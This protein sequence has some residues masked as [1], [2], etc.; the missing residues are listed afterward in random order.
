M[1]KELSRVLRSDE[2]NVSLLDNGI[3][4]A[5]NVPPSLYFIFLIGQ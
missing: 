3:D 1:Y 4:L 2:V 5:D